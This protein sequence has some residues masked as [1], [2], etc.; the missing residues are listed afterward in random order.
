S[1]IRRVNHEQVNK[2]AANTISAP[3]RRYVQPKPGENF[4]KFPKFTEMCMA[5]P[6]L[7]SRQCERVGKCASSNSTTKAPKNSN[8]SKET[9]TSC[10]FSSKHRAS[11]SLSVA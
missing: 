2:M 4:L 7:L 1:R 11:K 8:V 3:R 9:S 6:A 10:T 5:L